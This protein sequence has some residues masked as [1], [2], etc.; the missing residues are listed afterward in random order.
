MQVTVELINADTNSQRDKALIDGAHALFNA[1]TSLG[2]D[3]RSCFIHGCRVPNGTK[4]NGKRGTK[5]SLC[6]YLSGQSKT[7]EKSLKLIDAIK[8]SDMLLLCSHI[9]F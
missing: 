2:V 7:E 4:M 3:P 5:G 8:V 6:A 9:I 1:A